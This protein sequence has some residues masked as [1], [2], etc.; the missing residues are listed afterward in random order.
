M[1]VVVYPTRSHTLVRLFTSTIEN[2]NVN[3]HRL[4]KNIE[5]FEIEKKGNRLRRIWYSSFR[6]VCLHFS[7]KE[8]SMSDVYW[9]TDKTFSEKRSS[10]RKKEYFVN[11]TD[12]FTNC[13]KRTIRMTSVWV[14]KLMVRTVEIIDIQRLR[15]LRRNIFRDIWNISETIALLRLGFLN[16]ILYP[17]H[18]QN[19]LEQQKVALSINTTQIPWTR[20]YNLL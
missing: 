5:W 7:C 12:N 13:N 16:V 6:A 15:H 2:Y 4:W 19:I 10:V 14:T 1:V 20:R 3:Y 8:K 17:S 11:S 9:Q 18:H